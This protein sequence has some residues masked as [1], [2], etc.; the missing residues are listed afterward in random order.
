MLMALPL[1]SCQDESEEFQS[2]I[3]KDNPTEGAVGVTLQLSVESPRGWLD[4]RAVEYEDGVEGEFMK[5]WFVLAVQNGTIVRIIKSDSYEG[6]KEKDSAFTKLNAGETTFYSFANMSLTDVGLTDDTAEGTALPDGFDDKTFAVNGNTFSDASTAF[7]NGIPMSNKQVVTITS[8]TGVVNLEVVRM[9]AKIRLEI[10]NESGVDVS[11]NSLEFGQVTANPDEGEGSK[12]NLKL[13]PGAISDGETGARAVSLTSDTTHISWSYQPAEAIEIKNNA[14]QPISF[15]INESSVTSDPG[16]FVIKLNT[17]QGTIVAPNYTTRSAILDWSSI[18]RNE[19]H[20]LPITFTDY[21][22]CLA[23][24]RG[25]SAIGVLPDVDT[26]ELNIVLGMYGSYDFMLGV[27]K[28]STGEMIEDGSYW[29]TDQTATENGKITWTFKGEEQ[30]RTSRR[31]NW[32]TRKYETT[33]TI[34]QMLSPI[35]FGGM[36]YSGGSVWIENG[37]GRAYA[38]SDRTSFKNYFASTRGIGLIL[39]PNP[40]TQYVEIVAGNQDAW[41]T[42]MVYAE[43]KDSSG[44]IRNL[45]KKIRVSVSHIYFGD[46]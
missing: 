25:F 42:Y 22:I 19:V 8:S 18:A 37:K 39:Y 27:K 12:D 38:E 29:K 35:E 5:S 14:S 32:R 3:I 40:A 46:L 2:D 15:Y 24:S 4:T 28:L 43:F 34:V 7:P 9:V 16:N 1:A 23:D 26:D 17:S 30:R 36:Y 33:T 10:K 11:I 21:Q 20:V 44:N 41:A 6:E 31:Y 13:L 45:S